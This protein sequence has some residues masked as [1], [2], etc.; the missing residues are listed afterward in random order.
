M[1]SRLDLGTHGLCGNVAAFYIWLL[2]Q[3]FV[4]YLKKNRQ[5]R[6]DS[7][8]IL[9][10]PPLSQIFK[11]SE[12]PVNYIK[13]LKR[14]EKRHKARDIIYACLFVAFGFEYNVLFRNVVFFR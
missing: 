12:F 3:N 1:K 8:D 11:T 5:I 6:G 10:P 14:K 9:P 13:E 7:F 4:R 2:V